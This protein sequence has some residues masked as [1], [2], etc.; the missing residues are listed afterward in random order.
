MIPGIVAGQMRLTGGGDIYPQSG[1]TGASQP[2]SGTSHSI[3]VGASAGQRSLVFLSVSDNVS[4]TF[5]AGWTVIVDQFPTNA[6]GVVAYRDFVAG[7][8]SNITVTTGSS[9][10]VM[11]HVFKIAAGTFDPAVAPIKN[12]SVFNGNATVDPFNLTD[13]SGIRPKLAFAWCGSDGNATLTSA[14]ANMISTLTNVRAGT[15]F[16]SSHLARLETAAASFDP[17][18]FTL[19]AAQ[20]SSIA[21]IFIVGF[22]A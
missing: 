11:A 8:P 3:T 17:D 22:S 18:P 6:R 20:N 21:T 5:P 9:A 12:S 16:C 7:D 4:V 15:P 2:A 13:P 1:G 19:S 10:G 14:P